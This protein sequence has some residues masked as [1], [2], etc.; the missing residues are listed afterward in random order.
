ML[1]EIVNVPVRLP[2]AVGLKVTETVQAAP[3]AM[4]MPQVLVCEKSPDAAIELKVKAAEP[5][6]L[7]A[8]ACAV[9]VVPSVWDAKVKLVGESRMPGPEAFPLS[10]TK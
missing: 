1:S 3:A 9:L 4:L 5:G 2:V 8:T 7:I 10:A 6:L